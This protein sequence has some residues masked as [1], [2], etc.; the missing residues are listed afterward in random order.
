MDGRVVDQVEKTYVPPYF[1][2][3][4][5][6]SGE[7]RGKRRPKGGV[8]LPTKVLDGFNNGALFLAIYYSCLTKA[9]QICAD[10]RI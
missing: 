6:Y 9:P 10:L 7:V 2:E 1:Y 5:P 4:S 3:L 8:W